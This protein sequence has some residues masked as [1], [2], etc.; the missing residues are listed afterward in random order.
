MALGLVVG[1]ADAALE[2]ATVRAVPPTR[3]M[4]PRR[5]TFTVPPVIKDP[6]VRV[7]A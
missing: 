1:V 6:L 7:C 4:S 5:A 3:T 2:T